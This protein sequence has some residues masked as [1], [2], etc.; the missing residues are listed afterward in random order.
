MTL[1]RITIELCSALVTP[2]KGDTIWG[3]I[4]WGIAN[5]EGDEAVAEFL[6]Q[7]KKASPALAVSNAFP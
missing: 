7:E 2:L 3:H 1:Y 5:H 4:V 6:E